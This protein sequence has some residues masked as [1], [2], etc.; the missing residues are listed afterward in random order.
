MVSTLQAI[1]FTGTDVDHIGVAF[2]SFFGSVFRGELGQYFTMRPIARF[3]VAMLDIDHNHFVL[4]PTAGSGGFLLETLLQ[5][6]HSLEQNF[7]GQPADQVDRI[8]TDFALTKVYGIEIHEVLARIC[9]INL[10]LHNDGHTNIEGDRSCLDTI[11]TRSRLAE[12]RGRF[13]RIV[14]N[15]PFGDEVQ[16]GDEDHLGSNSLAN[17]DVAQGRGAVDS[18]HIVLERNG[19]R[20]KPLSRS[21]SKNLSVNLDTSGSSIC[22]SLDSSVLSCFICRRGKR[23][24]KQCGPS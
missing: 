20:T 3:T 19:T 6:W 10:L 5:A 17:F 9:K 15:P 23:R 2:E 8:K 1:S 4:D 18:E 14:G 21:S 13:H 11:F 22:A 16:E 24:G 12:G 7:S